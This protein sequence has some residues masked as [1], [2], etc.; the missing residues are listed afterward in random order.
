MKFSLDSANKKSFEE[1]LSIHDD[2]LYASDILNA[3]L[4]ES[5]EDDG[6]LV[7]LYMRKGA[8]EQEALSRVFNQIVHDDDL[9]DYARISSIYC[10]NDIKKIKADIY[11]QTSYYKLLKKVAIKERDVRLVHPSYYPYEVFLA[12]ETHVDSF[13]REVMPLAYFDRPFSF[14]ALEKGKKTWMSLIP[15]EIN[16][17]REPLNKANGHIATLGLGLGYFAFEASEKKEVTSIDIIEMDPSVIVLF[18]KALLPLF[19]HKEKIH[20]IQGDAIAY[21]KECKAKYDYIF[22]DLWHREDDALPLY[23]QL[24]KIEDERGLRM[25][26]WIE[27]SILAYFRRILITLISEE[28]YG[29]TDE[30]YQDATSSLDRIINSLHLCLKDKE[31]ESFEDIKKILGEDSLRQLAKLI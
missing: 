29:S 21:L 12:D 11:E 19:P 10:F 30:D 3:Y 24:R 31:I 22:S 2:N 17:M 26:Y 13:G 1:L 27:K 28:Y 18:K 4:S 6:A 14:P 16:T 7:G 25:D 20:I 23:S 15:H 5:H 9:E 8:K